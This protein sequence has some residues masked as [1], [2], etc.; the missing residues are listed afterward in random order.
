MKIHFTDDIGYHTMLIRGKF[1]RSH[2]I[3]FEEIKPE[4]W[5]RPN[6]YGKYEYSTSVVR[7]T[8]HPDENQVG[9]FFLVEDSREG[10]IAFLYQS[11][12]EMI[13]SLNEAEEKT[14][15]KVYYTKKEKA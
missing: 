11:S 1:K 13:R 8:E 4:H 9:K 15:T 3:S 12:Y 7:C 5:T 14:V 2:E 6:G 10:H